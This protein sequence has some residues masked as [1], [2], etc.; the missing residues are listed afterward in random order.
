VAPAHQDNPRIL[1]PSI[2][3]TS[4]K[5]AIKA[6]ILPSM[7]AKTLAEAFAALY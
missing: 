4:S 5:A 6:A 7:T 2:L 1:Q 3:N